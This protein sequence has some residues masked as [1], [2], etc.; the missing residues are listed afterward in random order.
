MAEKEQS[1]NQEQSFEQA[2][3]ALEQIVRDLE[4]GRLGL[5]ES[6]TRY[7]QGVK[8]L[9]N[10]YTQLEKVERQIE[11]LTG[12]DAEGN[13][14]FAPFDDTASITGDRNEPPRSRRSSP[15]TNSQSEHVSQAP[16][17]RPAMDE[18]GSLF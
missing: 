3:L 6:M 5:A 11:L 12:I 2:L 4:D 15:T 13:A 17:P 16:S 8:L 9:R 7:E 18:P 10:C 1:S 14:A